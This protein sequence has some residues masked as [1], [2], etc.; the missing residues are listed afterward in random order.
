MFFGHLIRR[1]CVRW[2]QKGLVSKTDEP[3]C[4]AGDAHVS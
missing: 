4:F 2:L 3:V 1:F